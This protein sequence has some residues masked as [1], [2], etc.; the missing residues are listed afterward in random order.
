[1]RGDMMS[2]LFVDHEGKGHVNIFSGFTAAG[3]SGFI[4]TGCGIKAAI[5]KTASRVPRS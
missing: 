1:M 4:I 3:I 2:V 5:S